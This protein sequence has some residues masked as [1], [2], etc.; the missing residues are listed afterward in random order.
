VAEYFLV[1]MHLVVFQNP[2]I[3]KYKRLSETVAKY[4]SCAEGKISKQ[5]QTQGP[6]LSIVV[7]VVVLTKIHVAI[8][9]T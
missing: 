5:E 6:L 7:V 1:R 3:A 2:K 4:S 8:L 9:D